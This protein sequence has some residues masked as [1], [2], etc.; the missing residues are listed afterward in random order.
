MEENI[1]LIIPFIVSLGLLLV[2]VLSTLTGLYN[3]LDFLIFILFKKIP[4]L[5][6]FNRG[7]GLSLQHEAILIKRFKY[8]RM[9]SDRKKQVFSYRV[10]KFMH[11]KNFEGRQGLQLTDE[12]KVLISATAIKL[13]FGYKNFKMNH[14]H[15]FIIYPE[16]FFSRAT[17]TTNKGETNTAGVVVFSWKDFLDG[18]Q[19]ED[20]SINLGYHELAHALYIDERTHR[21]NRVFAYYHN[22]WEKVLRD[23]E[24]VRKIKNNQIF[25]EYATANYMEFFAVTLENFFETPKSFH[26]ELPDLYN[27]MTK[28]LNQNPLAIHS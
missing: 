4:F 27:L 10:H 6:T 5:Y 20:D 14:F 22:K 15:T 23:G 3:S 28:M 7:R 16:A 25:R 11:L 19:N 2:L 8:Y 26:T 9:L 24:T 17:H 12:M 13:T 21:R 18:F 1:S